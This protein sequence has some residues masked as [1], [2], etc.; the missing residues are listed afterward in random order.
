MFVVV[1]LAVA[2]CWLPPQSRWATV[3]TATGPLPIAVHERDDIVS[4]AVSTWEMEHSHVLFQ[5]R[6]KHDLF[7]DIGANVGVHSVRAAA[8]GLDVLAVEPM[9]LNQKLLA[10]TVC[11]NPALNITVLPVAIGPTGECELYSGNINVGDCHLVCN[12][13][14]PTSTEHETYMYRGRTAVRPV[15]EVVPASTAVLKVDTEGSE[16][17]VFATLAAAPSVVVAES[18]FAASR[19]CVHAFAQRFRCVLSALGVADVSLSCG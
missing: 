2:A 15:N 10:A 3:L 13:Q 19:E 9:W 5:N 6:N 4:N 17:N 14:P 11:R 8:L 7:V 16:C 18:M 1:N 12:G